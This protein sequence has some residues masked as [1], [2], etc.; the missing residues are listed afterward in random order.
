LKCFYL[1][2]GI[3]IEGEWK[4][5]AWRVKNDLLAWG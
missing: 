3:P 4:G 5:V 1:Y 2:V